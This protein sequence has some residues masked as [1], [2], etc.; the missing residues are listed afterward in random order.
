MTAIN[1]R[2]IAREVTESAESVD[3]PGLA[4]ALLARLAPEDYRAALADDAILHL[5]L[6][7]LWTEA[8]RI[9]EHAP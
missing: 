9:H 5:I 3:Y 6:R 7:D 4:D 1:L 2:T 8:R